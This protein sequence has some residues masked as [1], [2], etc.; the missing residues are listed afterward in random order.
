[1][2]PARG[3]LRLV[4]NILLGLAG[5]LLLALVGM[6]VAVPIL[7]F[8]E[9]RASRRVAI[10]SK[11]P[12]GTTTKPELRRRLRQTKWSASFEGRWP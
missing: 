12:L 9:F 2:I 10:F 3:K 6:V 4:R 8:A 7:S 11:I 1:M 5:L